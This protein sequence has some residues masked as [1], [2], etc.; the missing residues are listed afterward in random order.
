[1]MARVRL[2]SCLAVLI[3]ILGPLCSLACLEAPPAPGLPMAAQPAPEPPECHG[4]EP[5][6]SQTPAPAGHDCACDPPQLALAQ[7]GA[8]PAVEGAGLLIPMP[9]RAWLDAPVAM[10]AAQG[11]AGTH[12]SLPPPDILLLT[13]TFLL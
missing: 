6:P 7:S 8:Q 9:V 11:M 13:S 4:A 3:G 12:A 1:M 5:A 2:I 10:T